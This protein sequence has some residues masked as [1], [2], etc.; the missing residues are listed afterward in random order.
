MKRK[1]GV[2]CTPARPSSRLEPNQ[3]AAEKDPAGAVEKSTLQEPGRYFR[4]TASLPPHAHWLTCIP[5]FAF[6]IAAPAEVRGCRY[7]NWPFSPSVAPKPAIVT[8]T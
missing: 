3:F 4:V 8:R 2:H 6:V 1:A 7:T 5:A